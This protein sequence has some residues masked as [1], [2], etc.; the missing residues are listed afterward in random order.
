MDDKN[1]II[2]ENPD[3]ESTAVNSAEAETATV[4]ETVADAETT[5]ATDSETATA[6]ET[7]TS[8]ETAASAEASTETEPLTKKQKKAQKK[9]AKKEK[10]LQKKELKKEKKQLKK[11]RRKERR[12]RWKEEK[13]RRRIELKERYKDAPWY[14]KV[15][16]VYL[17]KP[18]IYGILGIIAATVIGFAIYGAVTLTRY[19]Y[20]YSLYENRNAP[21]SEEEI[22]AL[23]PIDE[24]GAKK[25]ESYAPIGEDESWAIY[26]YMIG[27]N[28]EDFGEN[29]MSLTALLQ[30][31]D[32]RQERND[33]IKRNRIDALNR[34]SEELEKNG[35]T[36]P[37]YLYFPEHPTAYKSYVTEEVVTTDQ[38]GCASA[39]IYE[40]CT[41]ELRDNVNIVIQTG[42]ATRWSE[43]GI[44]PNVTQRFLISNQDFK[45]VDSLPLQ[46]SV[47]PD[48]LAD[49]LKFCKTNYPADHTILVLWD[50]GNGPFGYGHDDIYGGGMMSIAEVRQ[51]LS[52]VYSPNMK[53]RPF[54]IIG[55]DACLMSSVE[56]THA[57][58]GFA[59]FYALSAELEPGDGWNYEG[60]LQAMSDDPTLSPAGVARAICD[61]YTDYYMT[62]NVNIGEQLY[63]S[64]TTFSVIEARKAEDLYDAYCALTKQ[65]LIDATEDI[66][67]LAEIGRCTNKSIHY[68]ASDYSILN[69]VD[70]GN[71]VD[72]M[73]DTYPEEC[74]K[75]SGLLEETVLYHRENG[76][77]SDSEGIS[78]YIP[79][80]MDSY[81]GLDYFLDYEYLICKDAYTA[82][83]YYYKMAGCLTDDMKYDIKKISTHE[84]KTLDISEFKAFDEAELI[85][86]GEE[87]RV[88]ISETLQN[89]IQDHC[90]SL[91][92]YNES[93]LTIRYYG[94]DDFTY[95]D[96]EG[97]ICCDFNG[98]WIY[99]DGEPLSVE[100]TSKTASTI[101]YRSKVL[102]NGI[103]SY[104]IFAYDRDS[105]DFTIKGVREI[106]DEYEDTGNYLVNTK[107]NNE[108]AI[109]DKIVPLYQAN[110]LMN[111]STYDE[112][113]KKIK[114]KATSKISTKMLESGYYLGMTAI[115]D[116]RGDEYYSQVVGYDI[117]LGK[118]KKVE[119]DETFYGRAY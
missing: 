14:I 117:S 59:D 78:V 40:M 64:E 118:L 13:K 51:A 21:V 75:I 10:K 34:Y 33:S 45:E 70:L 90:F 115:N 2:S 39:D 24:E 77:M 50:H 72:Y 116:Q 55:F 20:I 27:S 28:L 93:L 119:I 73:V 110:N 109:G 11:I 79:G 98:E 23:S 16:R 5:I 61:S 106:P 53:D 88:P 80:S 94:E 30:T 44:N 97:N 6:E 74:T 3:A 32:E 37:D 4:V 56:V 85:V 12:V 47:S 102:W 92:E 22:Y 96:G 17:L 95:F 62:Q 38:V 104:L 99:L 31:A 60:F 7:A 68:C 105:E 67:V 87:Y 108:L 114:Y 43:S 112:E 66:S 86:E 76:G 65:Q 82:M 18:V 107:S 63:T 54:D 41:P 89:S 42:G 46:N 15:P 83:L 58:D 52:T 81:Y 57:L 29:D 35:L 84:P 100:M 36:L 25:I 19:L 103:P 91:A 71:Y 9:A 101:E 69:L 26:V 49:F 113:G 1:T 48:T 8:A 111:G